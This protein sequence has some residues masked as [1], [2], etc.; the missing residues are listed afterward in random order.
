MCVCVGKH[1]PNH[2]TTLEVPVDTLA[3]VVVAASITVVAMDILVSLFA[4][5]AFFCAP[6]NS[7]RLLIKLR[8]FF[9]HSV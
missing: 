7:F 6:L 2:E 8:E 1:V 4:N 9:T 3:A 5:F